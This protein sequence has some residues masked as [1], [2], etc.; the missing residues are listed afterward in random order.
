MTI[1]ALALVIVGLELAIPF[2]AWIAA[3]PFAFGLA[4]GKSCCWAAWRGAA[5][6]A[7]S[8]LGASLYI[9]FT[10]GRIIAGRVAAMFGLGMGRGWLMVIITGLL[11]A[12][13]A[14]LA[15]FTGASFRAAMRKKGSAAG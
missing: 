4:L 11:G 2:W 5:A 7:L 8:W 1:I 6:G 3:A 9:Y 14:G 13:V 10:S 12:I 15:A